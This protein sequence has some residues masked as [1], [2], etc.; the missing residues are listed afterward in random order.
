MKIVMVILLPAWEN[1]KEQLTRYQKESE[2]SRGCEQG[3]T[4]G[5]DFQL[6]KN[7][8]GLQIYQITKQRKVK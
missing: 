4:T 6:E 3:D 2:I 8:R 5:S 1:K 7:I